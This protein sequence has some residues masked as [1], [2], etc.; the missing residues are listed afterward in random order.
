M[1]VRALNKAPVSTETLKFKDDSAIPAWGK[2]AVETAVASGLITGDANNQFKPFNNITRAEMAVILVRAK[3][4]SVDQ[5]ATLP[6]ATA[7][8]YRNGQYLM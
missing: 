6:F 2:S 4:I 7:N 5:T 8:R 1:L 3:G